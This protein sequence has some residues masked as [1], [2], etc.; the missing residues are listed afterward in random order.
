M[1]PYQSKAEDVIEELRQGILSQPRLNS[2]INYTQ[3]SFH[4]M[5][6]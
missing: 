3:V 2:D 4:G 5:N 6:H 1:A